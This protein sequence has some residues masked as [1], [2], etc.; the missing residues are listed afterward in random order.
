MDGRQCRSRLR[1]Q[2]ITLTESQ[3]QTLVNHSNSE[4]PNE[5][6]ALL[7][8]RQLDNNYKVEKIFLTEN[9]EKS[10]VNF[11]ISAEQILEA[12]KME[13]ELHMK[14][15]GIFHSHPNSKA[16]PSETDKKFME[17]NPVVWII[18]S[19]VSKEFKGFFSDP[20]I[21]E[22]KLEII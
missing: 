15:I 9:L 3:K 1:L 7:L 6:C 19:C 20:E 12:D 11:T 5:A 21:K 10:P 18:Y 17:L 8:G 16:F 14:I 4:E 2:E 13:K 22:I